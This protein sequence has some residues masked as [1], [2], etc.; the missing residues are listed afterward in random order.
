MMRMFNFSDDRERVNED[1]EDMTENSVAIDRD[2]GIESEEGRKMF[3][4]PEAISLD[5]KHVV[6]MK[7]YCCTHCLTL[8]L[9]NL[10]YFGCAV[11][12]NTFC[13]LPGS[14]DKNRRKKMLP[15]A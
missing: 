3:K 11:S 10:G 12:E 8:N 7:P 2:E 4:N 14:L 1:V 13:T 6:L 15:F 9:I 5:I